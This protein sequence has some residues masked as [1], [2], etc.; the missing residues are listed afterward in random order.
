MKQKK[1]ENYSIWLYE[2]IEN[3]KRI[4][5]GRNHLAVAP[6]NSAGAST[7]AAATPAASTPATSTPAASSPAATLNSTNGNNWLD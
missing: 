3:P 2:F 6:A 4:L 7:P 1:V 5:S